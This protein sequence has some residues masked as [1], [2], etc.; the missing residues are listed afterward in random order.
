[1]E[2]PLPFPASFAAPEWALPQLPLDT[3]GKPIPNGDLNADG[4]IDAADVYLAEQIATDRRVPSNDE[5]DRG[6]V[7]PLDQAPKSTHAVKTGDVVRVSIIRGW[8]LRAAT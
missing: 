1:M 6:D 7:A 4:K 3:T 2:C 8:R 5:V